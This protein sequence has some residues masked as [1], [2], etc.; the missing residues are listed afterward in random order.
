[1]AAL[2]RHNVAGRRQSESR[3][4]A[5]CTHGLTRGCWGDYFKPVAYSTSGPGELTGTI[6][7][8]LLIKG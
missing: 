1:M 6:P 3:V 8:A 4:R 5:N 7:K 2:H